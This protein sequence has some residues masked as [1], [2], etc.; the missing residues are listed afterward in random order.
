MRDEEIEIEEIEEIG[1]EMKIDIETT[2][3]TWIIMNSE[4]TRH[5]DGIV[6]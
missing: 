2:L 4:T 3:V 1:I 5:N 6:S